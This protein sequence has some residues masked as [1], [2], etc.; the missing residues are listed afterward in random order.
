MIYIIP[1]NILG[2]IINVISNIF[3]IPRFGALGAVFSLLLASVF[4]GL[5]LFYYGQK[6]FPLPQQ[7]NKIF[8][9]IIFFVLFLIPIYVVMFFEINLFAKFLIK[10]IILGFYFFIIIKLFINQDR[11]KILLKKVFNKSMK[12]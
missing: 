1:P 8:G 11:L 6:V 5:L 4:S 3:L 7:Y 9:Q 10:L 2:L 12:K